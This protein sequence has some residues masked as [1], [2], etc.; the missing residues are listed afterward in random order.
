MCLYLNAGPL[1][2]Q[3]AVEEFGAFVDFGAG[4]NGLVH[5]SKLQVCVYRNVN[6]I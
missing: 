5:I 1:S 4:T 2:A 6:L 3:T